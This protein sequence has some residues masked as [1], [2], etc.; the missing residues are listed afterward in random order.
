MQE[1]LGQ[2]FRRCPRRPPRA[3]H[4]AVAVLGALI[5]DE[6][7]YVR[8]VE[9]CLINPLKHQLVTRA[10]LAVFAGIFPEDRAGDSETS[11]DE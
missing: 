8:H 5:R 9:Y 6:A 10:R 2:S 3:G 11:G 7:D 4:L 1:P